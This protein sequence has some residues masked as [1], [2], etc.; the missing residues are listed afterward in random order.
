MLDKGDN[1]SIIYDIL[2]G[3]Y[4]DFFRL[5]AQKIK[6]FNHPILFRLNNEMNGDCVYILVAMP[7]KTLNCLKKYG[8]TYIRFSKITK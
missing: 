2:N 3:K 4:D 6:E 7:L 1:S 8:D 5:Y